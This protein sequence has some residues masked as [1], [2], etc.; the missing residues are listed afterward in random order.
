MSTYHSIKEVFDAHCIHR[1][2]DRKMLVAAC[3]LQESFVSRDPQHIAFFGSPLTGV[4]KVRFLD[5]DRDKLFDILLDADEYG[6]QHDV[7]ALRDAHGKPV[8]NQTFVVSK[9]IFNIASVWLMHRFATSEDL[10]EEDREEGKLRVGMYLMYKFL[11]S[12]LSHYYKYSADPAAARAAYDRLS[13]K[14]ILRQMGNWGLTIQR[15]VASLVGPGGLYYD[16]LKTL[17]SDENIVKM[18]NDMQGRIRDM[19]KNITK[20]FHETRT[21]GARVG[22]SAIFQEIEGEVSLR[23]STESIAKYGKYLKRVVSDENSF[24]RQEL[25]DV[26]LNVVTTVS[27]RS[28]HQ[29]LTWTSQQYFGQHHTRE[30]DTC[31]DLVMEHAIDYLTSGG[32]TTALRDA[33][34]VLKQLRGTYMSPRSTD[35][36]LLRVRAEVEKLMSAALRTTNQNTLAAARTAWVLYVVV[37][38][39]SMNRYQS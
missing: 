13:N 10:S 17:D 5:A 9:D 6:L 34:D 38:A 16:F 36:K 35:V 8:I 30:I 2:F 29:A 19:I 23:E 32:R 1:K 28:L 27:P 20:V 24:V 11:T 7:Y 21:D 22:M 14:F 18:I 31:I 25:M 37:R 12:L 26:V 33:V 39:L 3:Q 4:H 15:M